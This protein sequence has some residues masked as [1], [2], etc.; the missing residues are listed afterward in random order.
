MP[1]QSA[2]L[3][4][5]LD[6]TVISANSFPRWALFLMRGRFAHM[7][8]FR[9]LRL[10]ISVAAALGQRKLGLIKHEELKWRLQRLWQAAT[11]GDGGATLTAMVSE[12][13][14]LVRPALRPVLRLVDAGEVDA[15]LATAAAADYA[16]A[17]GAKLGFRHVLATPTSRPTPG[18]SN[19]GVHKCTAVVAQL[20]ALGWSERPRV[21]FTD[22]ED[23]LPLIRVCQSVVWFGSEQGRE[24]AMAAAPGVQIHPGEAEN[25]AWLSQIPRTA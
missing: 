15:I 18:P 21:L 14:T 6:G 10:T 9:R 4:F 8:A 13:D 12:L 22:H 7:D 23:D 20:D 2:V 24:A 3:L 19:V 5:D 16:T 17:F 25:P 1:D 11:A